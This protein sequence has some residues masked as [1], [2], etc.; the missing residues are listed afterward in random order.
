MKLLMKKLIEK[1]KREI[2]G[3]SIGAVAG[4]MYWRFVGCSSGGCMITSSPV[5]STIYGGLMG[6]F[7][8]GTFKKNEPKKSDLTIN[9]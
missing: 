2:I 4:W 9:S 1:Y 5:I 7:V 3:V 6:F 8:S